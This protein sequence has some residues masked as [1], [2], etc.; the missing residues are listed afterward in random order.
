[1]TSEGI[2]PTSPTSSYS[3]KCTSPY[4]TTTSIFHHSLHKVIF[5]MSQFEGDMQKW[6]ELGSR[7][8]GTNADREQLYPSYANF[9][10]EVRKRF[11]KDTE[12]QIKHMQWEKLRQST[13]QDDNQFFQ[14]FE[15]LAYDAGVHDNEQVMLT[16]IKK[17][18]HE[19]SK[20]TIYAADGEVPTTY[21]GWKACLLCMDYN[22]CLKKAEETMSGRVDSRPQA[23]KMTMPQKGGQILTY[24]PEKKMAT[25]MTYG[26]CS[27]PMDID[28][29]WAAAKCFWCSKLG[30]FKCDCPDMLKSWEEVMRRLNYYWDTHPTEEKTDS[31]IKEVKDS[32]KK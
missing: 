32:A 10:A 8:L 18:T 22:Y 19:T 24:M 29:A 15:E 14:K 9:K 3:V 17:A 23:Q 12:A 4:S 26:R 30:Y 2:L 13:Y 11:W 28:A 27:V 31:K 5:C 1:M 7:V 21:E 25:G 6:W 16:Q 20:N